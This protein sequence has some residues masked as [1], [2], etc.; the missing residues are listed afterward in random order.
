VSRAVKDAGRVHFTHHMCLV[1]SEGSLYEG[2][3]RGIVWDHDHKE[4]RA[5][6]FN[7]HGRHSDY[8][9]HNAAR[10]GEGSPRFTHLAH[11]VTCKLCR[12]KNARNTKRAWAKNAK[13]CREIDR[14]Y[15]ESWRSDEELTIC[16]WWIC[17]RHRGAPS[18]F[19]TP[20]E[21]REF[22]LERRARNVLHATNGSIV[23][24]GPRSVDEKPTV[25][26]ADLVPRL[27]ERIGS[28]PPE[29]QAHLAAFIDEAKR[30]DAILARARVGFQK[31][32]ELAH[33]AAA[34]VQ[35][36]TTKQ[37]RPRAERAA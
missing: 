30:T 27:L 17:C 16:C 1:H 15:Y 10:K 35:F 31:L 22:V 32:H 21:E 9:C 6:G 18:P 33:M 4:S 8:W 29:D 24:L 34:C 20:T 14:S 36:P 13:E 26:E 3:R 25:L 7:T 23:M 28:L 11:E 37:K 2:E 19:A 12:A 5:A